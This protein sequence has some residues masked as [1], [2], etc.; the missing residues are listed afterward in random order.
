M[1]NREPYD[2]ITDEHVAAYRRDGAVA[3]RRAF[4]P[5]WIEL[6]AEGVARNIAEPSRFAHVYSSQGAPGFFFGDYCSW[7]HLEEYRRFLTDSPAALVAQRMMNSTK[8]NLFHEHVLVKEPGTAERTPWHHDQPY[9]TGDDA[10]F[11]RRDGYM[12][13]PFDEVTLEPG[14]VMDCDTFPVILPCP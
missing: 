3:L 9:W 1:L 2:P 4:D 14:D 13:P 11:V 8:V 7:E 5:E 12:S 10:R 6:L